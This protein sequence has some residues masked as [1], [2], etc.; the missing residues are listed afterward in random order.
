MK[1][2]TITKKNFLNWWFKT[3]ADDEQEGNKTDLG[4]RVIERFFSGEDFFYSVEDVFNECEISVIPLS[5]LEEFSD[6]NDLELWELEGI[7]DVILIE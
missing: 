3:G 1:T 2:Y 7:N 4:Q 5:Y 6:T